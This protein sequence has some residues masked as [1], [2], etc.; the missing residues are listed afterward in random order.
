MR[1]KTESKRAE[2]QL[3]RQWQPS[4]FTLLSHMTDS[5]TGLSPFY[6][7]TYRVLS[8]MSHSGVVTPKY[9][10]GVVVMDMMVGCPALGQ[11]T[12]KTDVMNDEVTQSVGDVAEGYGTSQQKCVA[13]RY[14]Q[15]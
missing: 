10:S 4:H 11:T 5:A 2:R 9:V 13:D 8:N 3:S 6:R 1:R 7:R 15:N 12:A 14:K